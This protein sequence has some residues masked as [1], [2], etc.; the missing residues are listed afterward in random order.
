MMGGTPMGVLCGY[1]GIERSPGKRLGQGPPPVVG[2][3]L[4][5]AEA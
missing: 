3:A 1:R 4:F 5:L 2:F